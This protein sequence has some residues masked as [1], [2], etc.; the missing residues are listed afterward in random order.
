MREQNQPLAF[1]VD[2]R[3]ITVSSF[4]GEGWR[5]LIEMGKRTYG[6]RHDEGPCDWKMEVV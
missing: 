3:A 6:V 5:G 1:V 2:K 4:G